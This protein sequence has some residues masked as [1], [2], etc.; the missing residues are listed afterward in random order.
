MSAHHQV[1]GISTG[2]Y[3]SKVA[4]T[5]TPLD[6]G[7][8]KGTNIPLL[9]DQTGQICAAYGMLRTDAGY[10]FRG[11]VVVD[12]AGVVA[13]R[14]MSDLPLGLGVAEAL[15]VYDAAELTY[16]GRKCTPPGMEFNFYM[17]LIKKAFFVTL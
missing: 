3:L 5:Q 8:L 1:V 10:S 7:G 2:S 11:F 17:L 15:R 12:P 4:W 13:C 6:Q 9:S 16:R 14:T